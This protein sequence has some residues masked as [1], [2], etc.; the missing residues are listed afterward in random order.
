MAG[1]LLGKAISVSNTNVLVSRINN[2]VDYVL[3]TV[4]MVNAGT[5]DASV[6]IAVSSTNTVSQ[7]DYILYNLPLKANNS[8]I[9]SCLILNPAEYVYLIADTNDVVARLYGIEQNGTGSG[10]TPIIST[11]VSWTPS[12]CAQGASHTLVILNSTPNAPVSVSYSQIDA[13]GNLIDAGTTVNV[14]NTDINGGFTYTTTCTWMNGGVSGLIKTYVGGNIVDTSSFY[15]GAIA[16]TLIVSWT[17]SLCADGGTH[18]LKITG[19]TPNGTISTSYSQVNSSGVV[20]STTPITNIGNAD[21]NGVFNYSNLCTWSNGAVSGTVKTYVSGALVDTSVFSNNTVVNAPVIVAT[22]APTSCSQNT[23]RTLSV[24]GVTTGAAISAKIVQVNSSGSVIDQGSIVNLGNADANGVFNYS[25]NCNW[26]TNAVGGTITTYSNGSQIGSVY[27]SSNVSGGTGS[28]GTPPPAPTYYYNFASS[29]Y[30]LTQGSP[31]S[32][33]SY[34]PSKVGSNISVQLVWYYNGMVEISRDPMISLG[35]VNSTGGI[36]TNSIPINGPKG[37]WRAEAFFYANG[38][39]LTSINADVSPPGMASLSLMATYGFQSPSVTASPVNVAAGDMVTY[40][41]SNAQ[42]GVQISYTLYY[43]YSDANQAAAAGVSGGIAGVTDSN[44]N[45][46]ATAGWPSWPANTNIGYVLIYITNLGVLSGRVGLVTLYAKT[47]TSS[48]T[49]TVNPLAI[50]NSGDSAVFAITSAAP[51]APV[52]YAFRTYDNSNNLLGSEGGAIGNTDIN[53]NFSISHPINYGSTSKR[54]EVAVTVNGV[55]VPPNPVNILLGAV[56]QSGPA[57]VSVTPTSVADGGYITAQIFGTTPNATITYDIMYFSNTAGIS[58]DFKRGLAAGSADAYGNFTI[59]AQ[60]TW[61]AGM[62]LLQITPYANGALINSNASNF[63]VYKLTGSAAVPTVSI[64]P[65]SVANGQTITAHI[66][67]VPANAT[68]ATN[69]NIYNAG[70][71]VSTQNNSVAGTATATGTF[72]YSFPYT[73]P[74]NTDTLSITVT[75]NTV[76]INSQP[77]VITK[78]SGSSNTTYTPTASVSPTYI[79]TSGQSATFTVSNGAPNTAVTADT[80]YKNSSGGIVSA[81]TVYGQAFGTTN[82]SGYFSLTT[83]VTIQ[84]GATRVEVTPYVGGTKATNTP[85]VLTLA[86]QQQSYT[87][88]ASVSPTTLSYSGQ[89]VTFTTSGGTPNAAVTADVVYKDSNNNVVSGGTV[90]GQTFG[91]TNSSGY[92]SLSTPIQYA[93]P[94]VKLELT[95]YVGGTRASN[96]PITIFLQ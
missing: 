85:L 1:G 56:G 38:S 59:S 28:G 9:R 20:V 95:V 16:S 13:G 81:G 89:N 2:N 70:S 36:P 72:D 60:I 12:L 18:T 84:P 7:S 51:N 80:V 63:S 31:I 52:V 15:S 33:T 54:A 55:S 79:S 44:G 73:W 32:F 14:G 83:G 75:A 92:F 23:L 78:A 41:L 61:P 25:T 53:G 40:S 90:Y 26:V 68:I 57:T 34:S 4:N 46:T 74:A 86:A 82:S 94:Q 21:A 19:A 42:P 58:S 37:T 66:T 11:T 6:S 5:I 71:L 64:T 3:A 62:Y 35:V 43:N 69:T 39:L 22:W 96:A 93:L 65:S 45:L 91:T 30:N 27:I 50:A 8:V 24:T 47:A 17:P 87:P 49:F 88:T 67:G 48:P 29:T 76:A 77:I 10:G